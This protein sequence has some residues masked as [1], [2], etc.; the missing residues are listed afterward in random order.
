MGCLGNVIWFLCGGLWQG[1]DQWYSTCHNSVHK[2]NTAMLY[3]YRH[4][5]WY[6]ML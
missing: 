3:N 5:V 4:T 6:A 2:W 1:L